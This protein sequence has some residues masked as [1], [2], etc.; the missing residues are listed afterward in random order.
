[1][2]PGVMES[3]DIAVKAAMFSFCFGDDADADY[4]RYR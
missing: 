2:D 1:V 3:V 4:F